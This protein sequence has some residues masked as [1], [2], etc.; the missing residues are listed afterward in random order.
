M[1]DLGEITWFLGISF[2]NKEEYIDMNQTKYIE[3]ILEKFKMKDCYP[4][5]SPCDAVFR[6][7]D[8]KDSQVLAD[9]TLYREI[10]GSLIYL[11]VATRPDLSFIVSKLSQFMSNPKMCHLKAAKRVLRYL[12]GTKHLGLRYYKNTNEDISIVG[13]SDSDFGSSEDR[14]SVSGFCFQFQLDSSLISWKSQKQRTIALSSCEAEYVAITYAVQESKFL[15]MLLCEMLSVDSVEVKIG[16][17]NQSALALAN[18]PICHQ[19]SKHID[20]KY[21]FIR[22]EVERGNVKL[23]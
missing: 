22:D 20:V 17:D 16:V 19:R 1:S 15:K 11:M 3:K 21:H 6:T 2:I 7:Y 14:K 13:F 10:I 23:L 4:A 8:D 12:K 5:K 9:D 18:N